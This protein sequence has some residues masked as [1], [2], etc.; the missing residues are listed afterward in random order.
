MP[1]A[2]MAGIHDLIDPA[3]P[4]QDN[5]ILRRAGFR[6]DFAM[7]C[8]FRDCL[9][10]RNPA[11]GLARNAC[12]SNWHPLSQV[13]RPLRPP[14]RIRRHGNGFSSEARHRTMC[15]DVNDGW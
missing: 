3:R 1:L 9:R 7:L 11:W 13:A 6:A 14:D 8:A 15:F 5:K 10:S 2:K 4:S 12:F